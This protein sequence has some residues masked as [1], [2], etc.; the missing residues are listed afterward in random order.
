MFIYLTLCFDSK[1]AREFHG[2][3]I[4]RLESLRSVMEKPLVLVTSDCQVSHWNKLL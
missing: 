4:E 3:M 2:K 1:A